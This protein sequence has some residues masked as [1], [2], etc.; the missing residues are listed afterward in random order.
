MP[1]PVQVYCQPARA[2]MKKPH[3]PHAP[4]SRGNTP[5][6]GEPRPRWSVRAAGPAR[7]GASARADRGHRTVPACAVWVR[8]YV[9][10]TVRVTQ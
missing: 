9:P 1:S 2:R 5:R 8:D 4:A 3:T 10:A 7:V 6:E